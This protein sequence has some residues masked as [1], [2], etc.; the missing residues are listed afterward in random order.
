MNL[1]LLISIVTWLLV[2]ALSWWVLHYK[3]IEKNGLKLVSEE[4]ANFFIISLFGFVAFIITMYL[5]ISENYKD[6]YLIEPKNK[7][8]DIV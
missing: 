1:Y 7:K 2:G 3:D 5:Y 8:K 4:T 6:T